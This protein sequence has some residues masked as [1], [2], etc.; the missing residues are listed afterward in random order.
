MTAGSSSDTNSSYADRSTRIRDRAQQSWPALS[1]TADG[2]RGRGGR[3]VRVG[4]HDVGALAAELEGHPLHLVSA[5]RH[6]PLAHLGGAGEADLAHERVRHEPLADHRTLAG[7]DREHVLRQT[8]LEGE[9][10]EPD[11]G[12]R[13]QLRGLEH[14]RVA[15]RQG[16]REAPARDRHRE[17]PGHDDA[18]HAERL[19]ECQV[20]AAGH[21][22]LPTE[23][24]LGGAGV[25]VEAVA[26]VA[27]LP[28]GVAP[29]V[30]GVADFHLGE[31]VE[32]VV[33]H[34]REPP[35]EHG[36]LTGRQVPAMR[37]TL[38]ARARSPGRSLRLTRGGTSVTGFAVA[39]LMT[40]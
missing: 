1:K 28:A 18:D 2:G 7:D 40:V 13:G 11:G 27:R 20:D 25:I 38:R 8:G 9:L 31:L 23:H 10:A 19:E 32:V 24:P 26:D 3:D 6:D 29:G 17:V 12:E 33:H 36:A 34:R 35:Q 30:A 39:G 5:A 15:R 22:D 21:R 37:G 16:R 14:D 4:E